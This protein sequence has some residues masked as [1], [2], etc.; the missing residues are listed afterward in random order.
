[1]CFDLKSVGDDSCHSFKSQPMKFYLRAKI[2]A[3]NKVKLHRIEVKVLTFCSE[4][5]ITIPIFI[6]V[7]KI[8]ATSLTVELWTFDFGILLLLLAFC[9]Q[10]WVAI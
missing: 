2:C 7:I 1:M 8:L 9:D 3:V 5:W 10:Y 4:H 6:L